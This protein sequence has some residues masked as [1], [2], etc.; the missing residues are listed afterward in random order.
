M[1]SEVFTTTLYNSNSIGLNKITNL[2]TRL[3]TLVIEV[4]EKIDHQIISLDQKIDTLERLPHQPHDYNPHLVNHVSPILPIQNQEANTGSSSSM[5]DELRAAIRQRSNQNFGIPSKL[6][7][8]NDSIQEDQNPQNTVK[9][10]ISMLNHSSL[11][12]ELKEAFQRL[13]QTKGE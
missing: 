12:I 13:H 11:H 5:K 7:R 2:L 4:F 10:Q 9:P 3:L 6:K 8:V 1:V